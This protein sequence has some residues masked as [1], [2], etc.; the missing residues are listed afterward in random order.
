MPIYC[1]TSIA[2]RFSLA[3]RERIAAAITDIHCTVTGSL[4]YL[5]Q[6]VF[7]AVAEG[8][9]FVAGK[10]LK[11]DNITIVG[12]VRSER[13]REA[14]KALA[15]EIMHGVAA[16]AETDRTA[17]QVYIADLPAS[18]IAEWGRVATGPSEDAAADADAPAELR[19]RISSL[20]E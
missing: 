2:E 5:V 7:H 8:N 6:V 18:Q 20:N 19:E 11:Y 1:V 17:V 15:L 14:R 3:Q 12:H 4:P 13:R 16:I 10:H 9:M